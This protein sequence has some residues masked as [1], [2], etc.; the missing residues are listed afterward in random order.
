[1]TNMHKEITGG[2]LCGAVRYVCTS[3]PV[4][5][6]NC[7]CRSCQKVSGGVGSSAIAVPADALTITGEVKYFDDKADSGGVSSRGFCPE[8]GSRLFGTMSNVPG[9]VSIMAG[10]LD[11]P[12]LFK[13]TMNVF[14]ASAQPWSLMDPELPKFDAMPD[15]GEMK[16]AVP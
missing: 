2:C 14:V 1:M 16:T 8:C 13:P 5:S 11:D 3:E 10:G 9:L 4:F 15:M 6:G 7:H 12:S